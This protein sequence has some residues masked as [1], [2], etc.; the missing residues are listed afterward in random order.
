MQPDAILG[1]CPYGHSVA[2]AVG[3]EVQESIHFWGCAVQHPFPVATL[4]GAPDPERRSADTT[5]RRTLVVH[6]SGPGYEPGAADV[7]RAASSASAAAVSLLR[8]GCA[9]LIEAAGMFRLAHRQAVYMDA[10]RF[11]VTEENLQK[12]WSPYMHDKHLA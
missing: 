10:N 5:S 7:L 8:I 11:C 3:S 12:A 9:D 6:H 1:R 2:G 4:R